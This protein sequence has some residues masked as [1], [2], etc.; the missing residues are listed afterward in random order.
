MKTYQV[1]VSRDGRFWMVRVPEIDRSTQA[2]RHRNVRPMAA[3]LIE[4]MTGATEFDL[5]ITVTLPSEVEVHLARAEVLR[6][7]ESRAAVREL[8]AQGLSQ[9]EAGEVLGLSVPAGQP[10]R[11][12]V[13]VSRP[14]ATS[15][16]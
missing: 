7:E 6:A 14:G 11:Q 1:D 2:P 12:L 10:A 5:N 8:L 13:S 16:R 4:I 15:S 3:E 9:R